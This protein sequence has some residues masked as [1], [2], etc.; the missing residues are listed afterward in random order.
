MKNAEISLK[1]ISVKF[2]GN[3]SGNEEDLVLVAEWDEPN[4]LTDTLSG[5]VSLEDIKSNEP[6]RPPTPESEVEEL[7]SRLFKIQVERVS[8][9]E[10]TLLRREELSGLGLLFGK[11]LQTGLVAGVGSVTSGIGAALSKKAVSEIIKIKEAWEDT[12]GVGTILVDEN[13]LT[14]GS[15]TIPLVVSE[16]ARDALR[17]IYTSRRRD[18]GSIVRSE[19]IPA[20]LETFLSEETPINATVEI[21]VKIT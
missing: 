5:A 4:F 7:A 11:L 12:L 14:P 19:Q 17:R 20:E 13:T 8:V 16:G 21:D 1:E 10:F 3:R 18:R 2:N 9:I 6:W 15:L